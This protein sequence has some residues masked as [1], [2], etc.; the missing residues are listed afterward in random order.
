VG[1][2]VHRLLLFWVADSYYLVTVAKETY[3]Y[4]SLMDGGWTFCLIV[5]SIAAWQCPGRAVAVEDQR[6]RR[7]TA[8]P[9]AFATLGLAILV[10]AA[11]NQLNAV[12]VLLAAASLLAVFA[13]LILTLRENAGMLA[14]GRREALTDALTGLGNRR[15]LSRDLER[16][17][18]GE[19]DAVLLAL[20]DLDGFK[21]YND[22]YGHPAGDALLQR[23]GSKLAEHVDG[24]G[25]AYRMGGD[26]FCVLLPLLGDG[27]A[28][29]AA[30][31][32]AL[33]ER[34]P[35]LGEH[36]SG[37]ASFAEAVARRLDLDEEQ[38]EHIR[39]AAELHDVGRWPSPTRSSTSPRRSSPPSGSS[40]AA[41][42]SSASAS[43]PPRPRCGRSRRSS[44]RATSA[45]TVPATPTTSA[46]RRSC[47]APGSWRSATRS[48]R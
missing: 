17:V 33:A 28:Q 25:T 35:G 48:T 38:I 18:A 6:G 9:I 13:R 24:V 23:L 45:G 20:F 7:F 22:S 4:P 16:A 11:L 8:L 36:I 21:H 43:S 44:A 2:R 1:R 30:C 34:D 37:V 40:S 14:C 10:I 15:A 26:E 32:Q 39:H 47:S 5:L 3:T 41:T 19:R 42:R 27:D 12:A 31:A 29:A 46:A